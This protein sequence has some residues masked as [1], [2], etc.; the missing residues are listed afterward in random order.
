MI[1]YRD[2][3]RSDEMFSDIYRIREVADGLC[4]EVEGKMV[5][6]TEGQIADA[7]IGGNASSEAVEEGTD[8][9][10]VTDCGSTPT[11]SGYPMAQWLEHGPEKSKPPIQILSPPQ[12]DGG[13]E[14]ESPTSQVSL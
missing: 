12:E 14:P 10:V 9:T 2:C 5:T 8:P 13:I 11:P 6:R 3:I 7:L 4:L 1:I